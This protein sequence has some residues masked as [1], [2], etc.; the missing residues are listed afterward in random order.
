MAR[1]CHKLDPKNSQLEEDIG[2]RMRVVSTV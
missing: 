1:F 2:D